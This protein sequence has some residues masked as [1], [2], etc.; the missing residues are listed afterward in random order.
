MQNLYILSQ[1]PQA[2]T[3]VTTHNPSY[4]LVQKPEQTTISQSSDLIYKSL[5]QDI[6]F[7][8]FKNYSDIPNKLLLDKE[9]INN[10]TM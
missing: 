4:I 5:I 9:F 6:I 2:K 1:I 7:Q 10:I 3:N 8:I